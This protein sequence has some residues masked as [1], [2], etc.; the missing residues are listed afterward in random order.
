VTHLRLEPLVLFYYLASNSNRG[1]GSIEGLET[2]PQYVYFILF[3]YSTNFS[4]LLD[5]VYE[6]TAASTITHDEQG[7]R[8]ADVESLVFFH[9]LASNSPH[10][11]D[12]GWA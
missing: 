9:H 6:R 3:F 1:W 11:N 10:H 5:Y 4:F 2:R 8:D 12:D 7:T